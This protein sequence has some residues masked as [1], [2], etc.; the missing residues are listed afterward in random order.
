MT[1]PTYILPT[2][3]AQLVAKDIDDARIERVT[4][5]LRPPGGIFGDTTW[6]LG[7]RMQH[8]G[9]PGM[10]MT[11]I[12]DDGVA[13]SRS[14]GL[15]D[16]E[17]NASV[18]S[19]TLF[20]AGSISKS[21]A[22]F[23]AMCMVH[24]GRLS[25][26]QPVNDRLTTWR[27]PDNEYTGQVSVT[28]EHLLSHTGGLTVHGFEGYAVDAPVPSVSQ[29]LDGLAPANS[30]PVCVDFVPGSQW[31]YSG[32]GYTIA[33]LLMVEASGQSFPKL[34]QQH[35][36]EP[37][38]MGR[39]TF[40]N[41]LPIARLRRAA[42]GLLPDGSAVPGKR[43][44]YPEMAAAGLWTT[45]HDLALFALEMQR[46]LKGGSKL[47]DQ[48]EAINML[49]ARAG[50]DYGL[51]FRLKDVNGESYFGHTGWNEGFCAKLIANQRL[52]QGVVIMINA[53]QP[54][55]MDE[56]EQAVAHEYRWPGFEQRT[57]LSSRV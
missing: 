31:R 24:G 3:D 54:R 46:A 33:Q 5:G 41:P 7:E 29:I 39:S 47:L 42:E 20:Q 2:V 22:A 9:V 8:Y 40:E 15:A 53:N 16:R 4:N 56:L 32:G 38:G 51:G 21:V 36:L 26:N 52:G 27:I 14:Y 25:L 19:E 12:D 13:W 49:Q 45:S 55:F 28:L 34:M 23:G 37:I 10:A 30:P 1:M 35:V 48:T 17:A 44:T 18:Q 50:S 57:R 11:V 43:H 6:S